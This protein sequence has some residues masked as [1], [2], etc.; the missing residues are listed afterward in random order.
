MN[1]IILKILIVFFGGLQT[2]FAQDNSFSSTSFLEFVGYEFLPQQRKVHVSLNVKGELRYN[3]IQQKNKANEGELVVQLFGTRMRKKLR[4]PIDATEFLSPVMYI[5]TK[6]NKSEKMT[7]VVLTLRT[8]EK[9][10][11]MTEGSTIHLTYDIPLSYIGPK[12]AQGVYLGKVDIVDNSDFLPL[13]DDKSV[14]PWPYLT[15][16]PASTPPSAPENNAGQDPN[17]FANAPILPDEGASNVPLNS[18]NASSVLEQPVNTNIVS[19]PLNNSVSTNN[20]NSNPG[21]NA[22]T[23]SNSEFSNNNFSDLPAGD[24][25]DAFTEE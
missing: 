8:P 12:A 20:S 21:A 1:Q 11:F 19:P 5:R 3:I 6:E 10:R 18:A 4:R 16:A 2:V 13:L 15:Q 17:V 25:L 14:R 22:D 9:P 23:I 24:G 7:Q